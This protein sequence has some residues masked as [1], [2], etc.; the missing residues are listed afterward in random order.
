M[1]GALACP[2]GRVEDELEHPVS[3]CVQI[4]YIDLDQGFH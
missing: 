4:K 3:F 2:W 1:P